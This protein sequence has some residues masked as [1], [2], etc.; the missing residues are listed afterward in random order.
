MDA[1]NKAVCMAGPDAQ[2][3]VAM[4]DNY[5]TPQPVTPANPPAKIDVTEILRRAIHGQEIGPLDIVSLMADE[6]NWE[7]DYTQTSCRYVWVGP[8][9]PPYEFAQ[10]VLEKCYQSGVTTN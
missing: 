4:A 7:R 2:A 10:K 1:N 3:F 9:R 6:T 8:N 5:L